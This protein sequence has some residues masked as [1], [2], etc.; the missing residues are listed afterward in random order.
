MHKELTW[1][2][3]IQKVLKNSS[4]PM[5]VNEITEQIIADELRTKLGATPARTVGAQITDSIK[6]KGDLSPYIRVA[7]GTYT[8]NSFS[9]KDNNIH[10]DADKIIDEKTNIENDENIISSF[11]MFWRREE[12]DWLSQSKLLGMQGI[13]ADTI[14]FSKQIG[15]Y[16]LYSGKEIIYVGRSVDRPISRRLYEHTIDR[17]SAR[18]DTFSWFGLLP[19]TDEGKLQTLPSKFDS[20]KIIPLLESIL[21]E[22]LEPRQNRKR[23][24]NFSD[25]EYLQKT[26]PLIEK[27]RIQATISSVM[28][29]L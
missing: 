2:Q 4:E 12:I 8:L 9:K 18:W 1:N 19:L 22:A 29:K 25:I 26:D 16:L 20:N 11:G 27:K 6:K 14:D 3:A 10:L 24:D 21:I 15:I 17:L 7:K 13:G 5:Q 28:D 23:G